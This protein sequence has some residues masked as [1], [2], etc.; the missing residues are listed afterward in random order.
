MFVK[1]AAS[2]MAATPTANQS[3]TS[4]PISGPVDRTKLVRDGNVHLGVTISDAEL[5]AACEG[6]MARKGARAEQSGKLAR[7]NGDGMPRPE[8]AARI[9][10]ALNGTLTE[11]ISLKQKEKKKS[12]GDKK[13]KKDK[14]KKKKKRSKSY[15]SDTSASSSEP[16]TKKR[17]SK[18]SN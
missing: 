18:K 12:K 7:V 2:S 8:V 15:D 4:T 3:G 11:Q 5:F 6:R 17:K 13:G 1:S 10:A 16:K 14:D 9:E